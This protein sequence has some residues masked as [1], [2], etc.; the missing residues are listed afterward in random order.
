MNPSVQGDTRAYLLGTLADAHAAEFEDRYFADRSFFVQVK[1]VERKL[2]EDYLDGRLPAQDRQRFE[3]RYLRVPALQKTL[4]GIRRQRALRWGVPLV[5]AAALAVGIWLGPSLTPTQIPVALVLVPGIAKAGSSTAT[6]V[7]P[8][9]GS[10]RL[11]LEEPTAG[12]FVV[13]VFAISEDGT[14]RQMADRSGLR[15]NASHQL[16]LDIEVGT[17]S[18]GDYLVEALVGEEVRDSYMF[19]AIAR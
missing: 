12:T 11:A 7:L 14:R 16:M 5:V 1:A 8:A 4:A 6:L 17:L 13:R 19:K 3:A 9:K 18:P 2:I 10:V 15:V